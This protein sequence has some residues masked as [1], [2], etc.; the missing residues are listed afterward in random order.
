MKRL[1]LIFTVLLSFYFCAI[2]AQNDGRYRPP[3]TPRSLLTIPRNRGL[4]DGRYRGGGDGKYRGGNDGRYVPDDLGK[5]TH[6][7]NPG[8]QYSGGGGQYTGDGGQ[9]SGG[10]GQYNGDGNNGG[11]TNETSPPTR[12]PTTTTTTT[13]LKPRVVVPVASDQG[14]W[15]IIQ[16]VREEN[17]DGYHYLFETENKILAEERGQIEKLTEDDGLRSTGFY[18]YVG[19]DGQVYRV[20]YVADDNGFIPRGDHIPTT[21]PHVIKLLEYLASQNKL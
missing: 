21:P 14:G 11:S 20:D 13:T 12:K 6:K 16:D 3:S 10:G 8:G 17:E 7:D 2:N 5:Y 19:D 4:A 18:E 9:Y 15:K 1:N